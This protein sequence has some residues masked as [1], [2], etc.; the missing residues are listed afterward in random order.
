MVVPETKTG[1]PS[2]IITQLKQTVEK[3]PTD[4]GL[5]TKLIDQVLI[6]DQEDL[7]RS[8]FDNY[9]AIFKFDVC[10]NFPVTFE[11]AK[12]TYRQNNG[13]AT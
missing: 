2:D 5:W 10:N 3:S 1:P 9:L 12:L 4:H 6:K 11:T 13:V 8:I 7:V